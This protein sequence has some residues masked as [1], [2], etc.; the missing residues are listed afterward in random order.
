MKLNKKQRDSL[1]DHVSLL[2]E[3]RS[4]QGQRHRKHTLAAICLCAILCGAKGYEAIFD[5]AKHLSQA[6]RKRLRCR[7][8]KGRYIVPSKSTI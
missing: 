5:W 1:F 3:P 2:R 7:K 4:F 6:M 8:N